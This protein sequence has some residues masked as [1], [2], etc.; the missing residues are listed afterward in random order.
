MWPFSRPK[1]KKKPPAARP[2][3]DALNCVI[4]EASTR[5]ILCVGT[6]PSLRLVA[7]S[8]MDTAVVPGI[9]PAEAKR[10]LAIEARSYPEWS[11][12]K[13]W[14]RLRPTL[15]DLV[16][17]ELRA[18]AQLAA[19]KAYT[20]RL[21]MRA[22]NFARNKV[23]TGIFLQESVYRDKEREA[24]ALRE[25]AFSPEL[26]AQS[27]LVTQYATHAGLSLEDAA[28]EIL[29]HAQ[30]DRDVLI[31]TEGMRLDL[32]KKIRAAST[33][34]ELREIQKAYLRAANI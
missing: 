19:Q 10:M 28:D 12:D 7:E 23:S 29:L 33:E 25:G 13:S 2:E 8:M 11:L 9:V 1:Q 26:K 15:P 27:P 16:T 4:I 3:R 20:F 18:R 34:E 24:R 32:F 5:A 6:A 21:A 14:R 22:V 30:L 31:K 17:E